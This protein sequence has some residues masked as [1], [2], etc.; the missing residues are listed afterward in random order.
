MAKDKGILLES[1]TNELEVL[2]FTVGSNSYGINVAKVREILPYKPPTP[3]P[4]AH[5]FIEGIMMPRDF[6][7]TVV[8]LAKCLGFPNSADGNDMYIVTGFNNVNIA[9]HVHGISGITRVSWEDIIPPDETV[10]NKGAATATG[11]IKQNEKLILIL[12]FEKIV[13]DICPDI[14]IKS[15]E[16]KQ[17]THA[18]ETPIVLAEDS[19]LLGSL[20]VDCLKKAGYT[21]LKLFPNGLE[22]W[23]YIS[24]CVAVGDLDNKV[25]CVITDIEMPQ[26]DGHRLLKLIKD[27]KDTQKIPVIIFSSL[28]NDE[29]KRKGQSLGADGQLTK[30]EIGQLVDVLQKIIG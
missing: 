22:A 2:E 10:S 12:D 18:N 28:I 5:P 17:A 29:M 9:F 1:G 6:I 13:S 20:V 25:K 21:N 4:N 26:M 11:I 27:G 24:K 30:P 3:V 8:D 7:I 19:K 14:S 16:V 23:N 15:S